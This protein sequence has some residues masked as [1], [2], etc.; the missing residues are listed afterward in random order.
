MTNQN[1][2]K[3]SSKEAT[4]SRQSRH[5]FLTALVFAAVS[6]INLIFSLR[7][8]LATKQIVSYIDAAAVVSL[9]IVSIH[10]AIL[11]RK[12]E[13]D[14]GIWQIIYAVI[15]VLGIRNLVNANMSYVF[16][17][18]VA[19]LLPLITLT[20]LKQEHFNRGLVLGLAAASIY[21]VF[22]ILF[23]RYFPD[24]RQSGETVAFM[25]RMIWVAATV[26][27]IG[28][29][30]VLINQAQ[31]LLLSSKL[32]LGMTM[33]VIIPLII[34]GTISNFSLSRSLSPRQA[35][36]MSSQ[37]AYLAENINNFLL[38]IQSA[39]QAEA[40]SPNVRDFILGGR[41]MANGDIISDIRSD[42]ALET[43]L[44]YKR[45][46]ILNIHS[47][48]IIDMQGENILDTNAE[49]IGTYEGGNEYFSAPLENGYSYISDIKRGTQ[50]GQYMLVFSAPILSEAGEK[51]G[52]LRAQ[53]DA[54][55]LGDFFQVYARIMH[56]NE[57]ADNFAALLYEVPVESDIETDPKAVY[58]ILANSATPDW[59][60]KVVNRLTTSIVTPLQMH[61]VLPP[62][63]T[64]QLSMKLYGLEEALLNRA[65]TPTFEAQA[66]P[67]DQEKSQ[68]TDLIATAS[69]QAKDDWIVLVSQDLP[70]VNLPI[71]QQRET[72]TLLTV[73]VAV[74]SALLAYFASRYIIS[75][76]L[77]LTEAANRVA[78]GD[79]SNRIVIETEDEIGTLANA[80]NTMT[81]QL[82]D[83]IK[84]LEERVDQRTADI[85]RRAQQLQAAVEVGKVAVSLRNIENLL[86]Q[87]TELISLRFGFYHVGIF[88]LDEQGEYAVLKAANSE[89]GKRM[90]KRKH[91]LKVGQVGIV[92]YVTETGQAR[93]ALDVGQDAVYFDNPDLPA[94]RSEMALALIAG[95]RI[96]GAL[97]I[98]STKGNA[99]S[100]AD[101]ATLQVLA[102]QIAVSIENAR[103]F[104]ERDNAYQALRRAYGEQSHIGWQELMYTRKNYGYHGKRDGSIVPISNPTDENTIHEVSNKKI[105]L[106]KTQSTANLPIT[107]RGNTIG[108]LRLAKPETS[109]S[110]T[111]SELELARTLST[112]LSGALDSARLFDETRKQAEQ[113]YVVGEIT[114]KLRESMNVES[115]VK[116][117]AEEIYKLLDLEKVAIHF[118][119]EDGENEDVA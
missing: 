99:F 89:G 45:K 20:T 109:H 5:A 14:A 37:A 35:Q 8:S 56:T 19:V 41:G 2:P 1:L 116:L 86:S 107:V 59:N 46:D 79:F 21:L 52:V 63:S 66:F 62:G 104:E 49:N 69:L 44:S 81:G 13:K 60:Q 98:Q 85:E 93:I 83:L 96:L 53:Y 16:S 17:V 87:A 42:L 112:E 65:K 91:K 118:I 22:D 26:V 48:A 70:S 67:R 29:I 57:D 71:Q 97:D 6:F 84:T 74:L 11:I 100:D 111:D 105:V 51:I 43:L 115:I 28:Y 108:M 55:L 113:E 88:L 78:Q 25:Q 77:Y 18:L 94:T 27:V 92:G 40:Q 106:D 73:I 34:L 33:V 119:P 23:N 50:P 9:F 4:I 117:A 72:I 24:L 61:G 39:L 58:L 68:V 103:L 90:L 38:T 10:A 114:D 47:Y 7:I 15:L 30:Y 12:G 54:D 82:D 110:W 102:D 95:G 80:F 31:H 3:I 101:I 36:V 76:I 64:A 75:P 32:T